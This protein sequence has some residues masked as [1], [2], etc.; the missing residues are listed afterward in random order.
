MVQWRRRV[1]LLLR[2]MVQGW[3]SGAREG[4]SG[5]EVGSRRPTSSRN[6]REKLGG[7]RRFGAGE[8]ESSS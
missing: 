8:I 7:P 3:D 1:L 5:M 6:G 4:S 2:V